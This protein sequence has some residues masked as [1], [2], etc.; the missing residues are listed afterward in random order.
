MVVGID[1]AMLIAAAASVASA[2]IG[3][4]GTQSMNAANANINKSTMEM[5]WASQERAAERNVDMM[6][7]QNERSRYDQAVANVF[8]MN[9][10]DKAAAWNAEQAGLARDF[11]ASE[12]AKS[13]DWS[14]LM[15]SSA[16]QR[17]VRD[18]RSAGLN[19]ILAY[20]QGGA[21]T[22]SP[23]GAS[24]SPASI[25]SGAPSAGASSSA[26]SSPALGAPAQAR[27]EN[28]LGPALGSAMQGARTVMDLKQLAAMTDQTQAQTAYTTAATQQA[29]SQ[30]ALNSA[31][32]VASLRRA[33]L[34]TNQAA[35]SAAEIPL[36]G[37]QTA[38][39][40]AQAVNQREQARTEEDRRTHLR[41]QAGREITQQNLNRQAHQANQ[42]YGRTGSFNPVEGVSQVL[43]SIR[44]SHW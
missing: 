28:T 8:N 24:V 15:S 6:R 5:N 20:Q 21:S 13:R 42:T 44:R 39:A 41:E 1:D 29:N 19:P 7:E 31:E 16:Y 26:L 10:W 40:S 17:A 38:A 30:T 18:M 11:N 43:D 27:M 34:L 25:G 32:T 33:D 9:M 3:Y 12:A 35:V 37:A 23:T 2:G 4:A 14:S 22:P 36:R